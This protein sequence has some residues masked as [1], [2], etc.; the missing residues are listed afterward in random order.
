MRCWDAS[1]GT[2]LAAP[3]KRINH[4]LDIQAITTIFVKNYQ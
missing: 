1:F 3:Q 4:I 2:P